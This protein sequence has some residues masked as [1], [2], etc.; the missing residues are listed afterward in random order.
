M[1]S[2]PPRAPSRTPSAGLEAAGVSKE[3]NFPV[4]SLLFPRAERAHIRA[5]YGFARL[6]DDVGDELA[7]D[8]VAAL[9]HLAEELEAVYRGSPT[10]PVFRRLL[11]AV[12]AC[13]IP[14]EPFR[15]LI[16]ANLLDQRKTRYRTSEELLSYCDLSAN[17][18]GHL[19]LHVLG[20]ATPARMALSDRVCT[21]LQL[22]EHCQDVREDHDRGRIYL[23]QEDLR[24]FG[25]AEADLGR[26]EATDALRRLLAFEVRRTRRLLDE[27]TPILDTLDGRPR[28]AVAGFVAG[29]R[30]AL[31]AIERARFDVLRTTPKP[32]RPGVARHL[33]AVLLGRGRP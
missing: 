13:G 5:L 3:E 30:A 20:A 15:R 29:G 16:E 25:V 10:H 26:S 21:A 19:V 18:V 24:R 17:P 9:D 4:A 27:G 28:L 11:P 32:G 6:V 22:A 33:L 7:G 14:P 1:T 23:P 8:R 12:E 31:E 2:L